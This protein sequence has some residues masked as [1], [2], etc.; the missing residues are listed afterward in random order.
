MNMKQMKSFYK[1][2]DYLSDIPNIH[3]GGCGIAALAMKR[4]LKKYQHAKVTIVYGYNSL[5][6]YKNNLLAVNGKREVLGACSHA[7]II[8]STGLIIDANKMW[9]PD[10]YKYL[11]PLSEKKVV[12]S[13]N[14]GINEWND[15]F[16][17]KK[18][19]PRIERKLDIDLSDIK[20]DD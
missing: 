2:R 19:V 11:L 16:N 13:L 15:S 10:Q 3:C 9:Q 14:K 20:I 1:I 4:W 8:Q 12:T 7:G 18:W 17:R 6:Y 5:N